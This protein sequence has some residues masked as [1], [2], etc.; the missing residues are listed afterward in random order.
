[1]ASEERII[2][3]DL[4]TT[5]SVVALCLGAEPEVIPNPEGS[6]KTP[7]VVAF[8]ENGEIVVGEIARRQAATNPK[9]T[10]SSV[11]R[12]MG[13][14]LEDLEGEGAIIPYQ[15]VEHEGQ[16]LVDVDGMGYRPEQISAL[17]LKKLKESAEAYLGEDVTKAVITVPAHF[18]DLQRQA[19]LDAAEMAG[20][21]VVRLMNEP[22]AAA[23][24]YGLGQSQDTEEIVAVYDFGGGTF[25]ITLLEISGRTFE[26]LTSTGDSQLGGDDLDNT[27]VRVVVAEFL[28]EHGVDLMQDPVTL[29]RLKE[30]AER[31][32]CELSTT[33]RTSISLPFITYKDG[34]P[35]HLERMLTRREFEGLIE[36]YVTRTV[37]C[38]K[39]A[40]EEAGVKKADIKRVI[41][42]GG[43][44]RI[45]MVQDSVEEFFDQQA[46]KGVNP[47]EVVALGAA[48]QAGVFEGHVQEVVLLDV[49]PHTLGIEVEGGRFS[50]LI[51]KNATIPIKAA[52]TFT[53]TEEDQEFVRIHVLQGESKEAAE[54]RS[55][56]KFTLTGI[57]PEPAGSPRIRVTFYINA[58][59][60][61]E[62]SAE[63]MNS[64][65]Q[66]AMTIVHSRLTE[67]EK[68]RRQ[69]KRSRVKRG[70]GAAGTRRGATAARRAATGKADS[71]GVRPR[72][73][74]APTAG[75][76]LP[77][78]PT[79]RPVTPPPPPPPPAGARDTGAG[80]QQAFAVLGDAPPGQAPAR[81]ARVRE[82]TE[83]TLKPVDYSQAPPTY[84]RMSSGQVQRP[85]DLES[86]RVEP[87]EFEQ[88]PPP[89]REAERIVPRAP[90]P[91]AP[92]FVPETI[93][94]TDFLRDG[95]LPNDV[96]EAREL[97]ES[98]R[99]D[100]E[101]QE[102]YKRAL[103]KL[104]A[105]PLATDTS[106]AA[107][108]TRVLLHA[109]SG[110]IDESRTAL[111]TLRE[112]H[113]TAKPDEVLGLHDQL[114]ERFGAPSVLRD[115]GLARRQLGMLAEACTDIEQA[116]RQEPQAA[117]RDL[118][119]EL[120]R[121]RSTKDNDPQA[122]FKLVKLLLKR[123]AVDEAIEVLQELKG[124]EAYEQRAL[125][126]L[127][128]CHWQKNL[129]FLAWQ[130]FKAL[131]IDDDL[132]DILYR[133]ASDMETSDQLKNA[134]MVLE[135]L[136]ASAPDYLDAEARLR[137]LGY[138]L[139]L[140]REEEMSQRDVPVLSRESRFTIIEEINRGSMGII[141]KAKDKTLNEIVAV[142]VLNDYLCGDPSAVER[143][144]SE[145]RAAKKLSHPYIVRIHDLFEFDSKRFL[146]MEFIE[147]T[148]LKRMISERTSFGESQLVYYVIQICDAL[149]YAHQL[150]IVH[151]DIKPAN[152]MITQK[153]LVKITDFGIA[154]ILR[155]ED[156]T[157]SGTAVIGTPLYMAPEQ[158]IGEPVDGRTDI[159]AL[160]IMMYE[161]VS[162]NPPFYLG[163]IEYHHIHTPPP[164]LPDTV[165]PKIRRIIM[166]M[167]QKKPEDRYQTVDAVLDDLRAEA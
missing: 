98:G 38:C 105:P 4:G 119:A 54:N 72:P 94:E 36:N 5:N 70:T 150:G 140:Q 108:R 26:V 9:R 17:V 104:S 11:K 33:Q 81:G 80:E 117:D 87:Q 103:T 32:K 78:V 107:C 1:M 15:L 155:G 30:V 37:R 31:A 145:A 89:P 99:D 118:L 161:I 133:L 126:V 63:E 77:G 44:T 41:L 143:F 34:Q 116:M 137:K 55:L 27:I 162:G 50:P 69:T 166:K 109:L 88:I 100:A 16:L 46:F 163:N 122:M 102:I 124:H 61:V 40:L 75:R 127:G 53:T 114:L 60:V 142:K 97:A 18:D 48:T 20:L 159:Y 156:A 121:E 147:G 157:K 167:I 120:Y 83:R 92:E 111:A 12:L 91:G 52:K 90:L 139:K 76:A 35:L 136:V 151:R 153:N 21:E 79:G 19:T 25:D 8:L 96:V 115:R 67:D 123:N 3:I 45:P 146:S 49:T 148:D 164:D 22:T 71:S 65:R 29:R 132:K 106:F 58:D 131:P 14:T 86:T 125:K 56:G 43:T 152:I 128:L 2:G 73:E 158:I 130:S 129:H 110:Q 23:M 62:I 66:E 84:S 68:Q 144:K 101:A 13:Q 95:S 160:G 6:N 51:E 64:G 138:R 135:H 113:L 74:T 141:Y 93:R 10:I 134:V 28:E 165:S 39:K 47:D 112:H 59:G 57:P 154:K 24:A 149:S 42:V 85:R 7:S 82:I